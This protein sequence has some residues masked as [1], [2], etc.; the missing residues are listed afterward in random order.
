MT[1]RF[2]YESRLAKLALDQDEAVAV[3][4]EK[5]E[6]CCSLC[7]GFDWSQRRPR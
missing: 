6:V 5:H 3:M 7:H 1:R 2:Y 4:L